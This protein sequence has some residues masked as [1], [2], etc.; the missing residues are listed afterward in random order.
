M[1]LIF[2]QLPTHSDK[3]QMLTI[4]YLIAIVILKENGLGLSGQALSPTQMTNQVQ[5]TLAI[6]V[7]YY[8]L[9]NT[10]KISILFFYL[11]I[12]ESTSN[13]IWTSLTCSIAARK[14][15]EVLSKATIGFLAIFCLTC[16]ICV[17][18]QCVPL[19]KLWDF[20]GSVPETCINTTA[21][22]Y[23]KSHH[24]TTDISY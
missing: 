19:H 24:L 5:I 23:G 16:I 9:I 6:Q 14:R 12:G 2:D 7:I 1:L 20:T 4:G 15:L 11:R 8:F 13:C 21:L 17:L 10:I 3:S 22:F 18:A